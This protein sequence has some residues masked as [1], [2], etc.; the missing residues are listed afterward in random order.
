[1]FTS[2]SLTEEGGFVVGHLTIRLDA[3]RK[4]VK[5]PAYT[6]HLNTSLT[7]MDREA[8]TLREHKK[9]KVKLVRS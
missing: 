4:A 6:A 2:S 5:L 1:M 8:F 3:M 7:N 9:I